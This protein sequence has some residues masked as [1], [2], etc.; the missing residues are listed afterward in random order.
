MLL[1]TRKQ[2]ISLGIM[3][4]SAPRKGTELKGIMQFET[5]SL[6]FVVLLPGG[7]SKK[8]RF[9]FLVLVKDQLIF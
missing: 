2:W 5:V 3:Q 1:V 7:Q 6:T 9:S 4:L 8:S